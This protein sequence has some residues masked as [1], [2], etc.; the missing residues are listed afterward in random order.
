M[1]TSAAVA[2]QTWAHPW[3]RPA[4]A[5]G[6]PDG[7]RRVVGSL[8]EPNALTVGV[9]L[10]TGV[11]LIARHPIARAIGTETQ[12]RPLVTTPAPAAPRTSTHAPALTA[13]VVAAATH[14]PRDPFRALVATGGRVLAPVEGRPT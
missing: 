10:V 12:V 11:V 14:A 6:R 8:N 7:W 2:P 4:P 5:R 9:V 1:V 13:P 3:A